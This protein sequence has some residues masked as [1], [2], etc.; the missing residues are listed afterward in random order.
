VFLYRQQLRE[1]QAAS[2]GVTQ[3]WAEPQASTPAA[4]GARAALVGVT[5]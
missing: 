5:V 4:D 2:P 3:A 1:S